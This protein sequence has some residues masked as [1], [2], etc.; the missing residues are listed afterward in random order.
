VHYRACHIYEATAVET[1]LCA[2]EVCEVGNPVRALA[3]L[4]DASAAQA[5]TNS[6]RAPSLSTRRSFRQVLSSTRG[7]CASARQMA[8][9]SSTPSVR[10]LHSRISLSVDAPLPGAS[11]LTSGTSGCWG[12]PGPDGT[13]GASWKAATTSGQ[14]CNVFGDCDNLGDCPFTPCEPQHGG[15][16]EGQSILA[17]VGRRHGYVHRLFR[18]RRQSTVRPV[19]RECVLEVRLEP[20]GPVTPSV[21]SET[22]FHMSHQTYQ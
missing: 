19:R 15:R 3:K 6:S 17:V 14:A 20:S 22:V 9:V 8:G 5:F 12:S 4:R 18:E 16:M 13:S 11:S 2:Q 1:M 21:C 7:W 10:R